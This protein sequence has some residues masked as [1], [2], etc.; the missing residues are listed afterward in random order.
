MKRQT[1]KAKMKQLKEDMEVFQGQMEELL[2]NTPIELSCFFCN[3]KRDCCE[4]PCH[5][6]VCRACLETNKHRLMCLIC[7]Q[8]HYP[9]NSSLSS[10]DGN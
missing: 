3:Q 5:H 7:H 2:Q 6:V 4:L 10:D 8:M 1:L 9:S